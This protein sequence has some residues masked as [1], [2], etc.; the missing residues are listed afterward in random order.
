[1]STTLSAAL[2]GMQSLELVL[3]LAGEGLRMPYLKFW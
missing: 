1:M 2:S 3:G